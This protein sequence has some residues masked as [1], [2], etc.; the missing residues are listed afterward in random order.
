MIVLLFSSACPWLAKAPSRSCQFRADDWERNQ[1]QIF[2]CMAHIICGGN[3]LTVEC[4]YAGALATST[5]SSVSTASTWLVVISARRLRPWDGPRS[6]VLIA[7]ISPPCSTC[8]SQTVPCLRA[9]TSRLF[10]LACQ[11]STVR[12]TFCD[13]CTHHVT[14]FSSCLFAVPIIFSA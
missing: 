1:K 11:K 14:D 9:K 2:T 7:F 13:L 8:S 5:V 12:A 10:S 3:I 4:M 6:V